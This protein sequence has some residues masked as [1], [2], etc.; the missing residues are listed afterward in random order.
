MFNRL[1]KSRDYWDEYCIKVELFYIDSNCIYHAAIALRAGLSMRKRPRAGGAFAVSVLRKREKRM[2]PPAREA[3]QSRQL[4]RRPL[5]A[6]DVIFQKVG[7]LQAGELDGEAFLEMAHDAALHC[8]ERDQRADRRP[9]VG[10]DT[11]ARL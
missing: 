3:R 4:S 9:L 7:M 8:A 10:G 2:E 5:P 1:Q 6:G 11:G